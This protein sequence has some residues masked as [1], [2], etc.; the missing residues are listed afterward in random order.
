MDR[1]NGTHINPGKPGAAISL[2][3]EERIRRA[4]RH[5][6]R[7]ARSEDGRADVQSVFDLLDFL[8]PEVRA[9]VED[10]AALTLSDLMGSA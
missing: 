9:L 10:E 8:V 2:E 3:C 1:W 4:V 5:V 7:C 6:V